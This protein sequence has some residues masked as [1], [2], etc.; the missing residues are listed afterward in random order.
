MQKILLRKLT[1]NC[2]FSSSFQ[3]HD[4]P[5]FLNGDLKSKAQHIVI[6]Y[7][8][9]TFKVGSSSS[10]KLALSASVL[11]TSPVMSSESF[12]QGEKLDVHTSSPRRTSYLSVSRTLTEQVGYMRLS[13]SE[14]DLR[15][16]LRQ[17][18]SNLQSS[19]GDVSPRPLPVPPTAYRTSD[20]SDYKSTRPKKKRPTSK[21][22]IT[23][24]TE[25]NPELNSS[26]SSAELDFFS[27][28]VCASDSPV[29]QRPSSLPYSS[30]SLVNQR[31]SPP[32]MIQRPSSPCSIPNSKETRADLRQ[33]RV[34]STESNSSMQGSSDESA[35][36]T[37][38][39]ENSDSTTEVHLYVLTEHSPMFMYLRSTWNNC[40]LVSYR[41]W[42]WYCIFLQ[43][44]I[45]FALFCA[46]SVCLYMKWLIFIVFKIPIVSLKGWAIF[47]NK[48]LDLLPYI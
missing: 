23:E 40:V 15:T 42:Q 4:Y 32:G 43:N 2:W 6:Q 41:A 36:E 45:N 19:S 3:I 13:A 5:E 1:I 27:Y 48:N 14:S 8:D 24:K 18:R 34:P 21:Q 10:V 28:A 25:R 39:I 29:V 9:L 7:K 37:D 12:L 17:E 31:L 47:H 20:Y 46:L 11:G 30:E 33:C 16:K 38:S 22:N 44:F 35:D 26:S